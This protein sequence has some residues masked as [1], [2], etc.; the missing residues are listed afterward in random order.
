MVTIIILLVINFYIHIFK[1]INNLSIIIPNGCITKTTVHTN[2]PYANIFVEIILFTYRWS[3][4]IVLGMPVTNDKKLYSGQL[5]AERWPPTGG[6]SGNRQHPTHQ[7]RV[8]RLSD[9]PPPPPLHLGAPWS[10][11]PQIK[12]RLSGQSLIFCFLSIYR[13]SFLQWGFVFLF[14]CILRI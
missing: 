2:V 9:T 12:L 6:N 5:Q 7:G 1:I 10:K 3:I 11:T 13:Y 4:F 8:G 14:C